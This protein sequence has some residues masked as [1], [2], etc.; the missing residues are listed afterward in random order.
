MMLRIDA[1]EIVDAS[2]F[3]SVFATAFGFPP[4]YGRNMDAWIDC[5]TFLDD[6]SSG[7]TSVHVAPGTAMNFFR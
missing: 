2:T 6:P 7:M 3:H 4:Y 1:T 5:L